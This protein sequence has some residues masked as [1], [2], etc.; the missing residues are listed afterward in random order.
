MHEKAL[1]E[2]DKKIN[3]QQWHVQKKLERVRNGENLFKKQKNSSG[4]PSDSL[5]INSKLQQQPSYAS[6]LSDRVSIMKISD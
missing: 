2:G 1:Y 3:V 6:P 4:R 5:S